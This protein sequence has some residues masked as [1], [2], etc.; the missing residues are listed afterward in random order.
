MSIAS[1]SLIWNGQGPV[2][3]GTFDPVK[4][5]PEMGYLTN[6]YSVGCGNRTLTA[7]PSRETT[8]L[9]ESCSGQ[10]L[11]LKELETSKSLQVSLS[12]VQFDAR[13]LAQAFF[14]EA[15][16]KQAGTVT[17]EQL[18]ELKPGD[19]FFLKYPR[20]KSVVIEDS[21]G[22]PKTYVEGTHYKI[23]DAAHS[24][25]QLIAHP[26]SHTEPLKVDYSYDGYVNIAAF[27]KTN[28]EKGLIF[29][30]INGDGQKVR[31]II[32]RISLAMSGDFGWIS[33]EPSELTLGGQALYVPELQTDADFGPFMRVDVMPD[34]P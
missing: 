20:S 9:K 25:Y 3:I 17:D 8:T 15:V 19:Y 10:R 28:V 22:S 7:T 5:R 34:L 29:S 4:G 14:G 11:T 13:T 16:V 24:R 30:G 12:M 2:M 21:T 26:D 32:P 1:T 33:D 18:A 27:S 31:V 23:S 6:I